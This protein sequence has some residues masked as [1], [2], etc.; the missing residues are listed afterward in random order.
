MDFT[1]RP[2]LTC[3]ALAAGLFAAPGFAAVHCNTGAITIPDSGPGVPYPSSL[4]VSGEDVFLTDVNLI[5][6]GLSHTFPDDVNLLLVGPQGQNIHILGDAGGGTDAVDVNLTF[7]DAAAGPIPDND[8]MVSGTYQRSVYG[9]QA[10][11]A[12]APADSGATTLATFNGTD[13]NGNWDLYVFD[14]AGIDTGSIAGGWCLEITSSAA[15]PAAQ[16]VPALGP[17]GLGL[18]SGL[19]GLGFWFGRRRS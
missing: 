1:R 10:F 8:P 16:A 6:N 9:A 2:L 12:P 7:D 5:I 18:L 11:P 4:T 15:P 19:L 14:D 3:L 13:P 17:V